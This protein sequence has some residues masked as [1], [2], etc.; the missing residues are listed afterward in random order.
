M[1]AVTSACLSSKCRYS[2][3]L[4]TLLAATTSSRVVPPTPR[5]RINSAA[6]VMILVLVFAPRAVSRDGVACVDA[7]ATRATL[8]TSPADDGSSCGQSDG[9]QPGRTGQGAGHEGGFP[10]GSA[11]LLAGLRDCR[12]GVGRAS[13]PMRSCV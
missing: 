11:V 12:W 13:H 6:A 7:D 4:L 8:S 1:T 3:D 2:C 5:T 10:A 9:E